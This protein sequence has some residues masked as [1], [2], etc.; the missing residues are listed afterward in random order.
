MPPLVHF[1]A[2]PLPC[3]QLSTPGIRTVRALCQG[4]KRPADFNRLVIR[5]IG[6]RVLG[7]RRHA[8]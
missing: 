2:H 6:D 8:W 3:P 7:N 5:I 1:S 4:N